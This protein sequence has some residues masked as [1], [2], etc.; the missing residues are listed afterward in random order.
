MSFLPVGF[1]WQV[2]DIVDADGI[3]KRRHVM[4]PLTRYGNVAEKQFREGERYDLSVIE[5]R[6]A[7]SHRF[8]FASIKNAFDSLP[9]T[10]APRFPSVAHLRKWA[11]V[12]IGLFDERE[13]DCDTQIN[14]R[15]LANFIR[16]EDEYARISIHGKKVIVRR[17]KSQAGNAMTKDEFQASSKAVL[18]LLDALIGT[19]RGTVK[20]ENGRHA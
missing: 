7:K 11:L 12:E 18:E 2:V 16:L 1:E 10:I 5:A 13:F 9:E 3:V 17:A 20:R 6:S 14:A 15:R 8:Y 4:M 19:P